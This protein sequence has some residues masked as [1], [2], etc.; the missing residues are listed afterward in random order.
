MG[1]QPG[2]IIRNQTGISGDNSTLVY[3]SMAESQDAY[4]SELQA[5]FAQ[6]DFD[7][8]NELF[9]DCIRSGKREFYIREYEAGD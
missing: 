6:P 7:L 2:K 3:K 8:M 4:R 9:T 1:K 5:D